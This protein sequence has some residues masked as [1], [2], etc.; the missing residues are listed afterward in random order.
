ML[1]PLLLVGAARC[2]PVPMTEDV[3][4]DVVVVADR[5]SVRDV[6][7]FDGSVCVDEDNDGHPSAVCGGDDCDDRNARR[8][9]SAREVCDSR[10]IDEDCNPCTVANSTLSGRGG[11]G[12]R[13]EDGFVDHNCFNNIEPGSTPVCSS[14]SPPDAGMDAGSRV[15]RV[16]V[17][18][19]LVRGTDCADDPASGGGTRFPGAAETCNS[20]DD[21]CDGAV[22]GID[23]P[24][25][26]ACGAGTLRCGE[27]GAGRCSAR[28]PSVE[29]C[30]GLD[31][32]CDPARAIDNGAAV[33]CPARDHALSTCVMGACGFTCERGFADCNGRP[34][35][36]CE[37]DT[38]S[39]P[40]HCD[41]CGNACPVP[42]GGRA[43]CTAGLCGTVC[44][45]P[46]AVCG[47]RC[48]NLT[49]SCNPY[50]PT[51][52]LGG[53]C[54]SPGA[55]RCNA[56][57]SSAA[58]EYAPP[59]PLFAELVWNG[60]SSAFTS[61]CTAIV[62]GTTERIA[63][64]PVTNCALLGGPFYALPAGGYR[65]EF[66]LAV[67]NLG[68][69]DDTVS[70]D[71][72]YEFFAGTSRLARVINVPALTVGPLTRL[73]VRPPFPMEFMLTDECTNRAEFRIFVRR[74]NAPS[75]RSRLV[76]ERVRLT[77]R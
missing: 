3:G 48:V 30:N 36:G 33:Q 32:D 14:E 27:G 2:G 76:L 4:T 67:Q 24:C 25:S 45:S 12:D 49:G 7:L 59:A 57:T 43:V 13:D 18:D 58:C 9:P 39:D 54:S 72:T 66:D 10:G 26:T 37:V 55:F 31:D 70:V 17:T 65:L 77:P 73:L 8:N 60:S 20:L 34:E 47:T 50:P 19:T 44:P 64:S 6:A 62:G 28:E 29:V 42:T 69:V 71:L 52:H 56:M 68:M 46:Q 35:D 75:N 41:R 1:L 63:S 23:V 22:D 74:F 15:A 21:D 51:T 5:P 11:D 61:A 38:R 53:L 40:A 16:R